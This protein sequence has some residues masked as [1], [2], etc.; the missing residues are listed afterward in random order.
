V[1]Q[2]S[3]HQQQQQQ[4]QQHHLQHQQAP[5]A[6]FH[7]EASDPV[8]P[9]LDHIPRP[10]GATLLEMLATDSELAPALPVAPALPEMRRPRSP[11]TT[12]EVV[13]PPTPPLFKAWQQQKANDPGLRSGRGEEPPTP[14]LTQQAGGGRQVGSVRAPTPLMLHDLEDQQED[15]PLDIYSTGARGSS[16]SGSPLITTFGSSTALL[17]VHP[18][19][20]PPP[21]RMGLGQSSGTTTIRGPMQYHASGTSPRRRI[22]GLAHDVPLLSAVHPQHRAGMYAL[23]MA[24][25]DV[26]GG[27]PPSGT[28]GIDTAWAGTRSGWQ[29]PTAMLR[30][31]PSVPEQNHA[32]G[33]L[34]ADARAAVNEPGSDA[35]SMQDSPSHQEAGRHVTEENEG[36][37]VLRAG[38]RAM[39]TAAAAAAAS[40]VSTAQHADGSGHAADASSMFHVITSTSCDALQAHSSFTSATSARHSHHRSEKSDHPDVASSHLYSTTSWATA[41]GTYLEIPQQ[42][43]TSEAKHGLWPPPV[44]S[45]ASH[46]ATMPDDPGPQQTQQHPQ[47][48][49]EQHASGAQ[50]VSVSRSLTP[51]FTHPRPPPSNNTS[52][53]PKRPALRSPRASFGSIDRS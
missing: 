43:T 25:P 50:L 26:T 12:Q 47:Q 9:P 3:H 52:A 53:S 5:P 35:V 8:P 51:S 39:A 21:P 48:Q 20:A 14:K 31:V 15:V 1:A 49:Q 4:Q 36:A 34:S 2:L 30:T 44:I 40:S 27:L 17:T 46:T 19:P 32:A 38:A 11:A 24:T 45:H 23:D 33:S 18:Q 22:A 10:T 41:T 7:Q 13:A 16:N 42:R 37:F 29:E 6:A 28:T